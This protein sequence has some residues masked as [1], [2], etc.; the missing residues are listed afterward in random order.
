MLSI[1]ACSTCPLR[2][3]AT[4][5]ATAASS[6][7]NLSSRDDNSSGSSRWDNLLHIRPAWQAQILCAWKEGCAQ[8]PTS[9]RAGVPRSYAR[10]HNERCIPHKAHRS[11]HAAIDSWLHSRAATLSTGDSDASACIRR[12]S[13]EHSVRRA[14]KL[15]GLK[16]HLHDVFVNLI[17][18]SENR[19]VI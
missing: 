19:G 3:T 10:A 11:D 2:L 8:A 16:D 12:R 17:L 18:R 15:R 9:A 1:D 4:K 7:V 13:I 5:A 14:Q 6:G